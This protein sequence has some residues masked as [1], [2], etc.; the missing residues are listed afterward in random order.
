MISVSGKHWCEKKINKNSIEKIK[1]DFNFTD[2]L[3]RLIISRN[4]NQSEIYSINN[5]I[6]VTNEFIKNDDFNKAADLLINSIKNN[7]NICILGDYDVDGSAATSLLV[8]YLNHINHSHFYYIPDREKD[9]YGATK[10]L[11]KKLILKEPKLII[12]LD[13]GSTSVEVIDYLN[14]NNIKSLIIDHHEINKPYP[15]SNIIINPKKNNGYI[16]YNYLCAT[17]LTYF[18][19]DIVIKKTKILYKLSDFLIYVLLASVCDVMPL[20]NINRIIAQNIIN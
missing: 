20:R 8:R 9:G 16:K 4:F 13:R 5:N 19:L 18:F 15:Q 7:E 1:Q 6:S 10:K 2:I 17:A 14:K 11:F 3:A 12:M